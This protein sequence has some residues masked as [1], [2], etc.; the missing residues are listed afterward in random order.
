VSP[1]LALALEDYLPVLFTLFALIW[2]SRVVYQMDKQSGFIAVFGLVLVTLGGVLKASG[3][4]IWVISE[5]KVD[6]MSDSLFLL[7]APGFA[8][9]V[10]GIWNGQ[11]RLFR[12]KKPYGIWLLPASL[13][14]L[15]VGGTIYTS[16]LNLSRIWF[17]VLL[18][19]VVVMS[20]LMIVL[21]SRHAFHYRQRRI[22]FL[23]LFYLVLT[24]ILNG[25]ARTP[26]P[27]IDVEWIKQLVNTA[28]AMIL[29]FA[30]WRLWV[31]TSRSN[32]L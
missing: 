24:L 10:W 18:T 32:T 5:Q 7:L 1:T 6:W 20:S 29:A 22:A 19:L 23:F 15:I 26:S 13:L 14:I 9:L 31:E 11:K 3:K 8:S 25:M 27:T 21:L 28:A 17:F 16:V 30:S 12:D 2:L 4:L